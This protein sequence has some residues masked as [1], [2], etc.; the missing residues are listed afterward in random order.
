MKAKSHAIRKEQILRCIPDIF[1]YKTMLY[2]GAKVKKTFPAGMQMVPDFKEAG[3]K[4]DVLEAWR[5]NVRGLL[6][7]NR[8][9]KIYRTIFL[10]DVRDLD[11][12]LVGEDYDVVVWWHGPEHVKKEEIRPTLRKLEHHAKKLLIV[13]CPYGLHEQG[14]AFGNPYEKHLSTIY[15]KDFKRRYGWHVD[16]IGKKDVT[17]SNLLAWKRTDDV[18]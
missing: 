18:I 14:E 12:I 8:E 11:H 4:I 2:I 13:A 7:M 1:E 5:P 10:G 9:K 3:Y 6:K 15:P 17:M 16:V